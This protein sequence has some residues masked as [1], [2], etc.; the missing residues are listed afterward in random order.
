MHNIL[1]TK[2]LRAKGAL[3]EFSFHS[4]RQVHT[5]AEHLRPR[6]RV[7]MGTGGNQRRAQRIRNGIKHCARTTCPKNEFISTLDG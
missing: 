1:N 5:S 7:Y 2:K 3:K 4:A 6:K